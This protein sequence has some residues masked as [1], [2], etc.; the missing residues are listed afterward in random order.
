MRSETVGGSFQKKNKV[1][2]EKQTRQV[3]DCFSFLGLEPE[4]AAISQ[5][6]TVASATLFLAEMREI[7]EKVRPKPTSGHISEWIDEAETW[8]SNL[9]IRPLILLFEAI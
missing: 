2:I 9:N 7:L 1:P 3:D 6:R 5:T 4:H 8:C